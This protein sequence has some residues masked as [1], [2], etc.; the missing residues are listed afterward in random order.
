MSKKA[1][2][3][4]SFGTSHEDTLEKTIVALE[5]DLS[6][7]FPDYDL[8]RAFTSGMILRVLAKRGVH[9]N[10]VPAALELLLEEGYTE[11][12]MQPTHIMNGDEYE[13][14]VAH[15]SPYVE[16]FERFSTGKALLTSIQDY[17]DTIEALL[18]EL[19]P[20]TEGKAIVFMGHGTE[21]FANA[22]YAMLDYMFHDM[23]RG[24]I[25][26]GTV[27]G[28]P[29][30]PQVVKKLKHRSQVKELELR[31]LMIV[32]GDH[33][34]NDL[35]GDEEDSWRT[36]LEEL[37]YQVSCTLMG[38]GEYPGIRKLFVKHAQEAN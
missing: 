16:R 5:Q 18:A 28:Y 31:P 36:Q 29:E 12:V 23:G 1:L 7:A 32:A 20:K 19:P 30:L 21:H 3:A 24:D 26:V 15:A 27:E 14:M 4:V 10:D 37:G 17:R 38:M 22:A 8:H 34:K 6:A 25:L 2:L 9:I 13:K 33:A 11:V 35:A